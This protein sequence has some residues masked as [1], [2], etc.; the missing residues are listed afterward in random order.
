M[1][2]SA[3][4]CRIPMKILFTN[5]HQR[6]G[7]GHVA[8]LLNLA[9]GL[10]ERHD[11]TIATPGTSRLYRYAG[12]IDGVTRLDLRFTT[13]PSSWFGERAHIRR[14]IAEGGYDIVHVNA[15][16]DHKQIMLALPGLRRRPRIILTKHNDHPVISLGHRCRARWATDHVIAVSDFVRGMLAQSP[17]RRCAI[18]TVRHGIDTDYFAPVAC[19]QRQVWRER[20]FG[21]L[22]PGCLLLGSSGG[23]DLAKGWLDLVA[24]AARLPPEAR[25]KIRI[26]VAGDPPNETMLRRVHESGMAKQVVFPGLLDD[27][28]AALGACDVGFVLSYREALSFACRELMGLGLPVLITDV[29]GLPENLADGEQGWIVPAREPDAIAARLAAMLADPGR[30]ASMGRAARCKAEREF[31]LGDFVAAT[32]AVYQQTLG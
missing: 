24:G 21:A 1:P 26:L 4:H 30:V 12:E 28:R 27:V 32:E 7:G 16:A 13:R 3:Q 23:T 2:D 5:Y 19:A 11:I 31:S 14:L 10:R 29:G 25:A 20:Y 15:S 8:Y 9:R 18:T 17:Y 22:P 6:N